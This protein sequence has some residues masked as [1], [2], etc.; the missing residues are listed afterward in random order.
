MPSMLNMIIPIRGPLSNPQINVTEAFLKS[1]T[2]EDTV[3]SILQSIIDAKGGTKSDG[4]VKDTESELSATDGSASG[5]KEPSKKISDVKS[6][7]GDILGGKEK[8]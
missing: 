4:A 8:K 6:L 1:M 5:G 7:F 3:N 2:S